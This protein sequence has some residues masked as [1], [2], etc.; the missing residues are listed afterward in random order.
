[1]NTV[2]KRDISFSFIFFVNFPNNTYSTIFIYIFYLSAIFIHPFDLYD[3]AVYPLGVRKIVDNDN[4]LDDNLLH[5]ER[6][7]PFM[8]IVEPVDSKMPRYSPSKI[9]VSGDPYF[10]MDVDS[11]TIEFVMDKSNRGLELQERLFNEHANIN[12]TNR[13]GY[14]LVKYNSRSRK[15]DDE[16]DDD[17]WE[18]RCRD[19]ITDVLDRFTMKDIPVENEIW[20]P[21]INQ[22]P[23]IE[24]L[25]PNYSAQV[26]QFEDLKG[27]KL[28]CLKKDLPIFEEKLLKRLGEIKQ[29]ELEKTLDNRTLTDIPNEKL[30]LM[31]TLGIQKILK[32]DVHRDIQ[33]RIEL[34]R[35][36][37]FIKTPEGQMSSAVAYLRER[38]EEVEKN[39]MR[40][41]P[42]IIEILKTKVGKRKLINEFKE[43]NVDCAFNVDEKN[44]RVL[45]LGRTLEDT[46]KGRKLAEATL[47]TGKLHIKDRDNDVLQSDEW[48][49]LC[50]DF[51]KRSKIRCHRGSVTEFH[52]FGLKKDV[53]EA[54]K[55]MTKFLNEQ[56]AKEGE[57]RFNSTVNQRL[58]LEF[59][60]DDITK[61]EESLSSY[62]VRI[63]SD[64]NGDLHFTGAV[65]GVKEV[66]KIL[67]AIQEDITEKTVNIT[68]PGMR[69]FLA[70]NKGELIGAVEKEHKCVLEIEETTREDQGQDDIDEVSSVSSDEEAF[71]EDDDTIVTQ[72]GKKIVWK[73][74]NIVEEEVV[75]KHM[76]VVKSH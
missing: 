51:E 53:D 13:D 64:G 63:S 24:N 17:D 39:S 65:E 72:E 3:F 40:N 14:V 20:K 48:K 5:V 55:A 62:S 36:S 60:N 6:Y 69:G 58:F 32:D 49:Q 10:R 56:K 50:R 47:I 33:A 46:A 26:K 34:A 70:K 27:L 37:I 23:R 43:A 75:N 8:G 12:W 38:E 35:K 2:T 29:A 41:P 18:K 21:V 76:T 57:F 59:Y 7:Y 61:L 22:L 71:D 73:I 25:F 4:F 68:L 54:M 30:K 11:D 42:E 44:K 28:I 16:F 19:I 52:V 31:E 9:P 45:F 15:P 66:T 1:M 67:N 74:G